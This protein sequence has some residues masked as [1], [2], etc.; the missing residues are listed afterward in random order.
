MCRLNWDAARDK[1]KEE[2]RWILVNI[3]DPSI[4]DCQ[5]LNRDIWKHDGIKETVQSNFLFMQYTKDDPQASQYTQYYFPTRDD[6]ASY[7][8]IAIVDPRTGEQVKLWSGQPSPK[9]MDF[10]MQLH[11]FL[12]RYSLDV[13]AKNPVAKR[14]VEKVNVDKLSE[15]QQLELALRASMGNAQSRD[16][17]ADDPDA[18]TKSIH[19]LTDVT[20]KV[21]SDEGIAQDKNMGTEEVA[22][23]SSAFSQIS[24][25]NPHTEPENDPQTTTRIQFRHSGG[26]VIR[27][28]AVDD[29]VRRIYE[30]L[31][32]EPL[33]GKEGVTFEL[34][35]MGGDLIEQIDV[36]I[37]GAKLKNATVMIEY[38]ED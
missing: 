13:T 12:D 3:Q 7:P 28:F 21:T 35:S 22:G 8:H 1:A 33:D 26:R 18:L 11:E 32:A 16:S 6:D 25:T 19:D 24:A 34:K 23:E 14:K 31:K 36:S 2:E 5:A 17:N 4:F 27:R 10:L 20:G 37:Q 29:P 30:W 9:P 15:E 38:L